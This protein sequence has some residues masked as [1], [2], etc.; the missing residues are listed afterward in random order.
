MPNRQTSNS[1]LMIRPVAFGFNQETAVNN[2]FQNQPILLDSKE[3]QK[4]ALKEF[5]EFVSVLRQNGIHVLVVEDTESPLTPDSIYPNNWVTFH[6][7]GRVALYPMFAENRREERRPEILEFLVENGFDIKIVEDFR[8]AETEFEFLE[9]TGSLILD[10]ENKICYA[11]LSERT[12]PNLVIEFCEVFDFHP[13]MF[14]AFHIING[15]RK[16]IYHTNIVL[17]VLER[18]AFVGLDSIDV[19]EKDELIKNLK[20]TNKEIIHINPE[21][22]SSFAGN[23]FEVQN[24]VGE[25]FIVMSET[26]KK[27]LSELQLKQI[28]EHAKILHVPLKTIETIGGGSAKCM[29]AEVFLPKN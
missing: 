22:V 29:I 28:N 18:L 11:A 25:H 4:T 8:D 24:D 15:E 20:K 12:H 17:S 1:V 19:E 23:V 7:D 9:G 6:G 2:H 16:T 21:Q 10:R 26:A 13:V 14:T 5:D 27:S 3:I